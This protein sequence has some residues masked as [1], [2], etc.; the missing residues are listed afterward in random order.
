MRHVTSILLV[1]VS[2]ALL[3][4]AARRNETLR[5]LRR[6]TGISQADPLINAPPLVTFTTVALGGFRGILRGLRCVGRGRFVPNSGRFFRRNGF[7]NACPQVLRNVRHVAE[8]RPA[9]AR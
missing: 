1:L 8:Y 3:T 2:V 7:G 9:A 5:D 6:A 4:L